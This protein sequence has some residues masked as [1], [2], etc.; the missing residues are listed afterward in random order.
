MTAEHPQDRL[1][2]EAERLTKLMAEPERGLATWNIF[3]EKT[4]QAI[5]QAVEDEEE[6]R[7]EEAN[8]DATVT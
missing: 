4:Y 6:R 5:R 2:L 8:N 7:R 3:V 1:V